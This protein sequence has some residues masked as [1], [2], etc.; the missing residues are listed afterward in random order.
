MSKPLVRAFRHPFIFLSVAL[1]LLNDHLL[2]TLAHSWATGK[3]SDFSGLFF[4]PFLI[5]VLLQ[6]CIPIRIYSRQALYT[7]FLLTAVVF[8]GIKTLSAVNGWAS[9]LLTYLYGQPI[10]IALDPSDCIALVMFIPA[11]VMWLGI[12]RQK[13]STAPGKVTYLVLAA[14]SLAALATAP[15]ASAHQVT[16]LALD[17]GLLYAGIGITNR[18]EDG[19]IVLA[20]LKRWED[21]HVVM[22]SAYSGTVWQ[23][24]PNFQTYAQNPFREPRQMPIIACDPA[25]LNICYRIDGTAEV[26]ESSD[27]GANWKIAWLPITNREDFRQRL[28]RGKLTDC[29]KIPDLQTFDL[30]L[31]PGQTGTTLLVA[32]GNEGLL[33]H[34]SDGGWQTI[35]INPPSNENWWIGITPTPFAARDP[36]EAI[37]V[38]A[39]EF[40]LALTAGLLTWSLLSIWVRRNILHRSEMLTNEKTRI[41][42]LP[43]TIAFA[44]T[45]LIPAV[46]LYLSPR[47]AGLLLSPLAY[48]LWI[49]LAILA[50][51]HF[52]SFPHNV[53]AVM[54]KLE[55]YVIPLGLFVFFSVGCR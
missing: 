12:E 48:P 50:A 41:I 35:G 10:K 8:T 25:E 15:C 18:I 21:W 44:C 6:A 11:W 14:G 47:N 26:K 54:R 23:P 33:V 37:N 22:Y 3:L 19:G 13:E 28:A 27:G 45:L 55:W 1:L 46:I 36:G 30:I 52:F 39:S 42:L 4:F 2:K 9:D 16:R 32:L 31:F 7:G 24:V 53:P 40:L 20:S 29:G 51:W 34:P 5:G 49:G 43:T 17:R 38:T